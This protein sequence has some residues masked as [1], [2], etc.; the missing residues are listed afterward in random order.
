MCLRSAIAARCVQ[1]ARAAAAGPSQ[2]SQGG[3]AGSSSRRRRRTAGGPAD[4]RRAPAP[5]QAGRGFLLRYPARPPRSGQRTSPEG[6]AS[7]PR[8]RRRPPHRLRQRLPQ[9]RGLGPGARP[10]PPPARPPASRHPPSSAAERAPPPVR[11]SPR[12][13]RQLCGGNNGSA[14]APAPASIDSN[15]RVPSVPPPAGDGKGAG[16]AAPAL[17]GP[18]PLHVTGCRGRAGTAPPPGPARPVF[19]PPGR[20]RRRETAS[21]TA[22]S[23]DRPLSPSGSK[24]GTVSRPGSVRR[25]RN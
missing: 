9:R 1:P 3:A 14:S 20:V 17:G 24:E 16:R 25:L 19:P 7:P 2:P 18:R 4:P 10:P 6:K 22:L 13:V 5:R 23:P 21:V 8:R 12:R 11:Q 15:R